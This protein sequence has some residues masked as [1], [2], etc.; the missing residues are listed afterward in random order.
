M[1]Q[2]NVNTIYRIVSES[3][4]KVRAFH[5]VSRECI[6]EVKV[7]GVIAYDECAVNTEKMM[8]LG[9]GHATVPVSGDYLLTFSANMVRK[10]VFMRSAASCSCSGEQ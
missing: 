1:C 7:S 10:R 3:S 2:L 8:N 6:A 9:T 5:V 4:S